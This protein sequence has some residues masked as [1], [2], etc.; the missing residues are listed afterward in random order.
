MSVAY[1]SG[2]LLF[3]TRHTRGDV[4]G[5][6]SDCRASEPQG[7][8]KKHS[9]VPP[10]YAAVGVL[11]VGNGSLEFLRRLSPEMVATTRTEQL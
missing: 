1:Q 10:M 8:E 5:V 9:T 7:Q 6:A 11:C 2:H 3:P 4:H